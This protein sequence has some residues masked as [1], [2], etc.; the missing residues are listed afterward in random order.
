MKD[1]A[2]VAAKNPSNTTLSALA[3][4]LTVIRQPGDNF[5]E[6]CAMMRREKSD[7]GYGIWGKHNYTHFYHALFAPHR[8]SMQA[9]LEV[10]LGTN[11]VD[12]PSNM[13]VGGTPGASLR[14]WRSYF[15]H[16]RIYGADIDKRILFEE[17]RISTFFIDQLSQ[18]SIK[19]AL[20]PF[21]RPAFDVILDDGLHR[22]D[23]NVTLH[24]HAMPYL[25]HGGYY[26]IEDI[27][28][29]D[30]NLHDFV[31]YAESTGLSYLLVKL[32]HIRDIS[33]NC[34]LLFENNR[35]S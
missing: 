6:L 12:T 25:R 19:D 8:N 3:T 16:S 4:A 35:R 5:T 26:I 28:T 10:G 31:S 15:P 14:A 17:Q 23:A 24:T 22:I 33:D 34:F 9:F 18:A 1:T 2:I 32:P 21:S 11:N 20:A 27:T 29:S 30:T 13:G 7:K